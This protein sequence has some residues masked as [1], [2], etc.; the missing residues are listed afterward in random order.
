AGRKWDRGYD[1]AGTARQLAAILASGSRSAGLATVDV[2]TLVIHGT[3]DKLVQPSGG[4][5]TA[6][7]VPDA[8]L[9]MIEGMGHDLP[10][11]LWGRIVDAVVAHA[12]EHP[13]GPHR[14]ATTTGARSDLSPESPSSRSRAPARGPSAG[15]CWRTW[16]RTASA[17][18][19]PARC[20]ARPPSG[21]RPTCWPGAAGPSASTSRP[22]KGSRSCCAS[23]SGPTR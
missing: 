5:R 12:T 21:R 18:T 15:W 17:W 4:E 14:A 9:L 10:P 16:G 6:E 8:K 19:G 3:A 2:P 23:S 20:R 22:R 7:V 1:P 13:G 11:P